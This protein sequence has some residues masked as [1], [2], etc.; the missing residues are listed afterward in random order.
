MRRAYRPAP[1]PVET[2]EQVITGSITVGWA[3]ALLGVLLLRDRLP[4]G[5]HWWIWTCAT[6]TG[7]GIFGLWYVPHFKRARARTA[8]RS[9]D[10]LAAERAA[11]DAAHGAAGEAAG[12]PT[13]AGD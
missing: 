8:Q 2:N 9:A 3:L 13:A 7:M 11:S 12:P 5:G 1:P 10:K 6:G 4:P